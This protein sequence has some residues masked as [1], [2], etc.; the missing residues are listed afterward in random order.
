MFGGKGGVGKTTCAA[1]YAVGLARRGERVLAVSTDPAHSLGDALGVRLTSR[2]SAVRLSRGQA[3]HA[4]EFDGRL[5]FAR[6]LRQHGRA[7][8][9]ILEHGSWLDRE[10]VD[11]LMRLAIPGVDELMGLLEIARLASISR[12]D[13]LVVD[14]APT[15]HTLRLLTSPETV[16]SVVTVLDA[17]QHEHRI[18]REQIARVS[19][20]EAADRLIA[21][22]A[23]QTTETAALLRDRARTVFHWVTLP[24][25]LSVAETSDALRLLDQTGIVI[26]EVIVNRVTPPG[27][28]CDLCDRR[29]QAERTALTAVRRTVGR[30]RVLRMVGAQTKEPRGVAALSRIGDLL[31]APPAAVDS[32]FGLLKKRTGSS[33]SKASPSPLSISGL[34]GIELLFCGGKGGVGKTTVAAALAL[35]L[36]R[37]NRDRKI[38]LLSTDPAHSLADVLGAPVTDAVH[39]IHGAP[40]NLE[41]RELDARAALAAR[42][43]HLEASLRALA[44]GLASG[45]LGISAS[46]G[47]TELVDLAPPG[48]DELLGVLSILDAKSAYHTI[49]VDTAPTGHALRLLETPAVAREWVQALLRI[50][51]KY[52]KIVRPG[53]LAGD[54][55][56]LSRQIRALQTLLRDRGRTRF[57]VVTRAAE[58]PRRETERLLQRLRRLRIATPSV[59]VN[60]LT[61]HAG[62][63]PRCR[64][65]RSA[66]Q[67][68]VA[69]LRRLCRR[70]ECVIIQTP[71][72]VPPPRGVAALERWGRTWIS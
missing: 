71:L 19:R 28:P 30:G 5:A 54:L 55:V 40:P 60:A 52:R 32:S 70:G 8:G 64:A 4:V 47:I 17:L 7:L 20:P 67:L 15:G 11:D 2:A 23:H 31:H 10:D 61:L 18:I 72:D 59:I 16:R 26:P 65:T 62:R 6:W 27:T 63:C 53:Q 44:E 57:V 45:Q 35:R 34:Q 43:I 58:L 50:L 14:T 9:D 29:R 12:P 46:R 13:V 37:V 56:V 33:L 68:E 69:R 25:E 3:V 24:E 39:S 66:E 41:A 49:I 38:L 48:I 51:L 1:A 42:R 36:S 21:L 22:L